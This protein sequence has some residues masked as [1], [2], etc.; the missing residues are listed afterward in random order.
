MNTY[1]AHKSPLTY[2]SKVR[3]V[4]LGDTIN[5]FPRYDELSS[6]SNNPSGKI[7]IASASSDLSVLLL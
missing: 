4:F 5:Q 3:A 6:N 1:L 7:L 2:L